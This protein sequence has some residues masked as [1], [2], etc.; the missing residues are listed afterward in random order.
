MVEG[1]LVRRGRH[2]GVAGG[3]GAGTP[4][5]GGAAVAGSAARWRGSGGAASGWVRRGRGG[6]GVEAVWAGTSWGQPADGVGQQSG[7]AGGVLCVCAVLCVAG[8]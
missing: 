1:R 8:A 3:V 4:R 7:V 2:V 6:V 5:R